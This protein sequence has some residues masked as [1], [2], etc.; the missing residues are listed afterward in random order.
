MAEHLA[1]IFGTEKDRV[2]CKS[3]SCT[4]GVSSVSSNSDDVTDPKKDDGLKDPQRSELAIS[5]KTCHSFTVPA[6]V[7]Q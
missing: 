3:L 6:R 2:N 4:L 5:H 7:L 1:S